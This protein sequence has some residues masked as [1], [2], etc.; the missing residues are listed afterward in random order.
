M[1]RRIGLWVLR[2]ALGLVTVLA[3]GIASL[4]I[5]PMGCPL[6]KHLPETATEIT[7]DK[8]GNF[9]EGWYVVTA[10]AS[11]ADFVTMLVALQKKY[12]ADTWEVEAKG[13]RWI[14]ARYYKS[15]L[16]VTTYWLKGEVEIEWRSF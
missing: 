1:V 8:R 3:L 16:L 9:P 5:F 12:T 4:F 13:A 6:A 14:L 15:P 7:C 2:L 10:K 11:R